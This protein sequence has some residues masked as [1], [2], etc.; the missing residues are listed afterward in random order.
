MVWGPL[1]RSGLETGKLL[2]LK[3]WQRD[4]SAS[5]FAVAYDNNSV[6]GTTSGQWVTILKRMPTRDAHLS[7]APT[8]LV[9]P[10]YPHLLSVVRLISQNTGAPTFLSHLFRVN[11][12]G[13]YGFLTSLASTIKYGLRI[14]A[15]RSSMN[16]K[17][18]PCIWGNYKSSI[19]T[20][21]RNWDQRLVKF[22]LEYYAIT[23]LRVS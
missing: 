13:I 3:G 22:L 14:W 9:A 5:F 1:D 2:H 7:S 18:T 4:R 23:S 12:L 6:D 17:E 21:P 19:N 10:P 20:P 11:S 16:N 8:V 15:K